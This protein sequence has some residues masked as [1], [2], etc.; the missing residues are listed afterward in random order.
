MIIMCGGAPC[1][2]KTTLIRAIIKE[3]G[4]YEEYEPLP[5]FPCQKYGDILVV[6]RYLEG[7]IFSGTDRLSYATIP[8]FRN[9]ILQEYTKHKHILIEGDRF[10]RA[11]DIE[12]L[13]VNF[14][15][16][17]YIL[18]VSLE[19]EKQRHIARGDNQSEKWLQTRRSLINNLQTNFIL[20]N[21]LN[22]R[23][24]ET[25][26]QFDEVRGEILGE[27]NE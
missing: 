23:E 6:G 16:K 12:W 2:G 21:D 10:F 5:L 9:F 19:I 14:V 26:E 20:M 22:I 1:S 4:S 17:I 27:L 3:L 11:K 8:K 15:A 24:T 7:Q 18:K 25:N 13:L